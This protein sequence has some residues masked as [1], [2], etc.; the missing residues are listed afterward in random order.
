MTD[1]FT[2]RSD[3]SQ[4]PLSEVLFTVWR[5]RVP[6]TIDCTQGEIR[7]SL[8]VDEGKLIFATSSAIDDS[9]GDRLL[10]RGRITTAQ[11]RES[12]RRLLKEGKRQGAILVEM[13]ALEPKDL[14][15]EVRDQVRDIAFSV[16][17]WDEGN[18]TFEPGR[19]R[20]R[21]FIRLD[22]PLLDAIAEGI[23]SVP[24]AKK[25]VA[26][27]GTR[28]TIYDRAAD[29]PVSIDMIEPGLRTI[30]GKVDGRHSLLDLASA[31][32]APPADTMRALYTLL[33]YRMIKAR[34]TA[35]VK[36]KV[37]G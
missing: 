13:G 6:G 36:V 15:V 28:T 18:V 7:K 10:A 27:L 31:G 19:E 8:F 1:R 23:R 5:H 17:A 2:F 3:L 24:D 21:E 11:Y 12:V 20:H 4:T 33:V 16:F 30:L 37:K 35:P 32:V 14:F 9:L 26:R 25:L 22:I 29:S 34:A